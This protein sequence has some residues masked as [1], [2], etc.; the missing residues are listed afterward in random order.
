M[1][2]GRVEAERQLVRVK[3]GVFLDPK[4]D[5]TGLLVI[6]G[7]SLGLANQRKP[8]SLRKRWNSSLVLGRGTRLS[9]LPKEGPRLSMCCSRASRPPA[10]F[11]PLGRKL[12]LSSQT[13]LVSKFF[14]QGYWSGCHSLL[15]GIFPTQGL[16]P[17]LLHCRQILY[18]LSHQGSPLVCKIT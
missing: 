18:C 5:L 15:Q 10:Q 11:Y 1:L 7:I 17:G 12:R 6:W 2:R 14:R 3:E 8:T 4:E 13:T 16:N 9:S